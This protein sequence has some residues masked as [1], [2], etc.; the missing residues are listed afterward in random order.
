MDSVKKVCVNLAS[1]LEVGFV[2]RSKKISPDEVFSEVGLLP[3]LMKRAEQ[4]SLLCF[5]KRLGVSF[6]DSDSA[7]LGVRVEM[8]GDKLPISSLMCLSDVVIELT[9]GVRGADISVDELLYD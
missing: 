5:N 9:R 1:Q 7:M 2:L 8:E 3:A 6:K 4:L